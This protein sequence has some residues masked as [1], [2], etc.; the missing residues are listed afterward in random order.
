MTK[1][2]I[3]MPFYIGDY[4]SDTMRLSTEQHGAYLLL[5]MECWK[6]GSLPD[7]DEQLA[8]ITRLSEERW[9]K[10]RKII[11]NYFQIEGGIWKNKRVEKELERYMNNKIKA[12]INGS[13]GGRPRQKSKK[14]NQ[15]ES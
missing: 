10:H 2:D 6:V 7:D 11:Q 5:L 3:W 12:K 4:L 15:N 13:K 14:E 9:S 8:C 1:T